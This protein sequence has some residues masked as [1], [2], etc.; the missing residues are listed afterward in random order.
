M[1]GRW[2][3]R[4]KCF[5]AANTHLSV[6]ECSCMPR[7]AKVSLSPKL[8]KLNWVSRPQREWNI[9]NLGVSFIVDKRWATY[10]WRPLLLCLGYSTRTETT[11]Q[12][13]YC[14]IVLYHHMVSPNPARRLFSFM[15]NSAIQSSMTFTQ[16]IYTTIRAALYLLIIWIFLF[17]I[18]FGCLLV[19]LTTNAVL[20]IF[21]RTG[22]ASCLHK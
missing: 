17:S 21:L 20:N 16:I 4:R 15:S 13:V 19:T 22:Q 5:P 12:Y 9:E 2:E 18:P 1:N 3:E 10:R 7:Q 14:M 8:W 6:N 11:G